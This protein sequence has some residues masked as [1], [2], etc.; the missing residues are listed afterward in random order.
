MDMQNI[1][2][3]VYADPAVRPPTRNGMTE[4]CWVALGALTWLEYPCMVVVPCRASPN[5][6]SSLAELDP[7]VNA[8]VVITLPDGGAVNDP[9]LMFA[10]ETADMVVDVVISEP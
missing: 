7:K 6:A 2:S 9:V 4:N 10:L 1:R 5:A 8:A 3:K